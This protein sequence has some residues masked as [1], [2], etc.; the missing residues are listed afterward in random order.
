MST[1][2]FQ[3]PLPSTCPHCGHVGN[4]ENPFFH[5]LGD[6]GSP[7]PLMGR[8]TRLD[9]KSGG[10]VRSFANVHGCPKCRMVFID[11]EPMEME[12]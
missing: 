10:A 2:E 3:E 11:I 8:R 4:P 1:Y 5:F 7:A 6:R 12:A 9:R